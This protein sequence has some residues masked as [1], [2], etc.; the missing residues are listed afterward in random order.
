MKTTK[1]VFLVL[2][3]TTLWADENDS[4]RSDDNAGSESTQIEAIDIPTADVLDPATYANDVCV[5]TAR[6][7]SILDLIVGPLRRVK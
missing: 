6:A 3:A 5:F 1:A 4:K 7:G 2:L